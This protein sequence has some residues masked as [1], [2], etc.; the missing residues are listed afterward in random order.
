MLGRFG[1]GDEKAEAEPLRPYLTT[2]AAIGAIAEVADDTGADQNAKRKA[3]DAK[4]LLAEDLKSCHLAVEAS[5]GRG[6]F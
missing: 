2:I 3:I 1:D 5:S 6:S 4:P